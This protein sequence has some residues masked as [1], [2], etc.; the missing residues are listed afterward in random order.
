MQPG[1]ASVFLDFISY[2]D[3]PLPDELLEACTRPVSILWGV[4]MT[5]LP[6]CIACCQHMNPSC[7]SSCYVP[8][9][10]DLH[11]RV[12][13]AHSMHYGPVLS[14]HCMHA[15]SVKHWTEAAA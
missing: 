9:F 12:H 14:V 4:P 2:S 11:D 7:Y 8:M 6:A 13:V 3:G 1:A 10:S 15:H 5:S